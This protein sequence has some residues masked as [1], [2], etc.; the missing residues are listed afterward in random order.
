MRVKQDVYLVGTKIVLLMEIDDLSDGEM[1]ELLK[2]S[3]QSTLPN[4]TMPEEHTISGLLDAFESF[5]MFVAKGFGQ[6]PSEILCNIRS[7]Y[8]D[9]IQNIKMFNNIKEAVKQGSFTKI[10]KD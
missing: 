5:N 1:T 6:D 4:S 3:N 9:W 2:R 10:V 7:F 8:L